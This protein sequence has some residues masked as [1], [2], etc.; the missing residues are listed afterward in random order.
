MLI[1]NA[2]KMS[3]EVTQCHAV[4]SNKSKSASFIKKV[5]ALILHSTTANAP[6]S[7]TVMEIQNYFSNFLPTFVCS[8]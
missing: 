3:F 5:D 7:E 8:K 4:N 2:Y 1:K 6:N